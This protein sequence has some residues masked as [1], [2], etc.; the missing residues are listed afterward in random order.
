MKVFALALLLL[1]ALTYG[2]ALQ[3]ISCVREAPDSGDCVDTVDTCPPE[4]DAC[5]KIAYPAPHENIFH[6]SCF[7]MAE[8]LKLGITQGLK[9]SCCTWDGCNK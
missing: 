7:K 9:V 3:C 1:V 6:K 4:M 5:A 2:E 8:C